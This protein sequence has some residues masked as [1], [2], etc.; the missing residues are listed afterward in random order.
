VKRWLLRIGIC[1]L[2]AAQ[3]H[4]GGWNT[5]DQKER[6]QNLL[7]F[8]ASD[9]QTVEMAGTILKDGLLPE[10]KSA[11]EAAKNFVYELEGVPAYYDYKVFAESEVSSE[12]QAQEKSNRKFAKL[13]SEIIPVLAY[14]YQTPGE[15][16]YYHNSEVIQ[17]YIKALEYC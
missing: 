6:H 13:F 12:K 9:Y 17:L 7:L 11:V 8:K 5:E 10:F 14:A 2:L 3:A 15:N 1:L 16:P 4:G